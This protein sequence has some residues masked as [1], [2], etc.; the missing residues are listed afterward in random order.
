MS[1]K[2]TVRGTAGEK[3]VKETL[4][5]T[6]IGSVNYQRGGMV[7]AEAPGLPDAFA[8]QQVTFH[9]LARKATPRC[10]CQ[11]AAGNHHELEQTPEVVEYRVRPVHLPS[12]NFGRL[13]CNR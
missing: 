5:K 1:R 6:L 7:V 10:F 13:P 9:R 8:R 3:T 12:V 2:Y 11:L 4:G